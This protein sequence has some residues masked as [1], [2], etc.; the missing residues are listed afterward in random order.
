MSITHER[1]PLH[2]AAK[3]GRDALRAT[4]VVVTDRM[5]PVGELLFMCNNNVLNN[6]ILSGLM[7]QF[8]RT[9]QTETAMFGRLLRV[10]KALA[11]AGITEHVD[12]HVECVPREATRALATDTDADDEFCKRARQDFATM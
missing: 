7:W 2:V 6:Q 1:L 5:I 11:D 9:G 12:W 10:E 8:R 4:A 3:R